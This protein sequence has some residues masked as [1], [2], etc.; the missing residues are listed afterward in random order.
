M[1]SVSICE[2]S[3]RRFSASARRPTTSRPATGSRRILDCYDTVDEIRRQGQTILYCLHE[4]AGHLAIFVGTK[5]AAKEH[6][7]F[8]NYMDLI[9]GMPPGLYEIVISNKSDSDLGAELLAGDFNVR[10]EERDLDDIRALGCN[11][12]EDEREFA[13]VAR[14]SEINNA[15]YSAFFQPWLK[16][17]VTPQM[18]SAVLAMQ[19]LRQKYALFSEKNPM[20]SIWRFP[21]RKGPAPSARHRTRAIPSWP[22]RINSPRR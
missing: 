7:E 15:M 5:V 10:I 6:S 22:C 3:S 4:T 11:S 14:V 20:I 13:A 12:I 16:S 17:L 1:A 8:I 2:T 21:G 9:D 18:A 19:P